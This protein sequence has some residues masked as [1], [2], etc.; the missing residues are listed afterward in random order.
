MSAERSQGLSKPPATLN[1]GLSL[2]DRAQYT[3]T[4]EAEAHTHLHHPGL[5]AENRRATT[6]IQGRQSPRPEG[7]RQGGSPTGLPVLTAV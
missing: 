3:R 1:E 2:R 4:S 7:S 6:H 5:S